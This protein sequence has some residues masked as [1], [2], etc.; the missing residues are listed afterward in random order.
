MVLF[1]T[2]G[3]RM[4]ARLRKDVYLALLRQEQ[5]CT[6]GANKETHIRANAASY[7]PVA[8][9]TM[10]I[11][12][13]PA[14]PVQG[15][16]DETRS[17]ELLARLS[18]DTT[19]VAELLTVHFATWVQS[20]MQIF[21]GGAFLFVLSWKLTLVTLAMVPGIALMMLVQATVL[22]SQSKR[23]MDAQSKAR[24]C[25]TALAA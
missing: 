11:S 7:E 19:V 3:E 20:M 1:V 9:C 23:A 13:V 4:V 6:A 10:A 8:G 5:A 21:V 14:D 2:V 22:Q 18:Q 15:F 17:D 24:A 16:F 12:R 25:C